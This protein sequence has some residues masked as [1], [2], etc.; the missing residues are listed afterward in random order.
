MTT[1]NPHLR[2]ARRSLGLYALFF[3][4]ALIGLPLVGGESL[5]WSRVWS[6]AAGAETVDGLIFF[7]QRL[8]RVLLA[9][10]VGGG[11]SVAGAVLQVLFRNPLAEP[12][13]LGVSGGAALG[14]F[15]MMILPGSLMMLPV[16]SSV[17]TG[18]L[19]GA[20]IAMGFVWHLARRGGGTAPAT[21]LLAGVT[22][23]VMASGAILLIIYFV[24]PFQLLQF[25]RWLMGGIE[26]TG[27]GDVLAALILVLPGVLL[28]GLRAH[29]YNPLAFHPE[30]AQGQGVDVPRLQ[31]H[32]FIG[33]GLI[34][35]G[36]VAVTGPIAFIGLLV[37]HLVRGLSGADHR[38]V[39]PG[40]FL[41]GGA[42]L[43]LCDALARSVI[44]PTEIPVG[45][46][47]A[48]VGGPIFLYVLTRQ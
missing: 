11:L 48:V 29:A 46:M 44:A 31:R 43:A 47:T 37:P 14:A 23:S 7:H 5:A 41:A 32:T 6:H 10:L 16:L 39:L 26:V 25:Q 18:A 2:S 33:A 20:V 38:L 3:L 17:Q 24:S 30:L 36:C 22:L 15:A 4:A 27:F 12:W 45:I 28:L 9:L 1:S 35:A 21:L 42:V 40:C 8:P 19:L 34:T 13:T